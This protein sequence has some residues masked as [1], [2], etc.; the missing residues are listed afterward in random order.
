MLTHQRLVNIGCALPLLIAMGCAQKAPSTSQPPKL[1][2]TQQGIAQKV[3]NTIDTKVNPC[4]DFYQYA[5]GGWFKQTKLPGDQARWVRSFNVIAAQNDQ[6]LLDILKKKPASL[7]NEDAKVYAH[8]DGCMDEKRIETRGIEPLKPWLKKIEDI[9][10]LNGIFPVLAHMHN[11]R[12]GGLFYMSIG[13]DA[14]APTQYAARFGQSGLGLMYNRKG[15]LDK[16]FE[17]LRVAYV[18]YLESVFARLGMSA[19]DAKKGAADVMAFETELAKLSRERAALRNPDKTYNKIDIKALETS[20]KLPLSSYLGSRNLKKVPYAIVQVPEFFDGLH[21]LLSKTD[22]ATIKL[23]LKWH[24]VRATASLLSKQWDQ[25][26]FNF[27]GKTL[28]GQKE[29][30]ARWKRCVS[31]TNRAIGFQLGKLYVERSFAGQSKTIANE[32]VQTI[33]G[34]FDDHLN[35]VSW[36]DDT[37]RKRAR[38]KLHT[39]ANKIGYPDQWRDYTA[40]SVNPKSHF[41]NVL[42]ARAFENNRRMAK[43]GQPV[44]H[45]DWYM[46]PPTVNAY[47]TPFGNQIVFPAGILQAPFFDKSFP[48]AMNFGGI[49]MVI[50]HEITHGFDDGGRKFDAKGQLRMWWEPEAIKKFEARAQCVEKQYSSIEVQKGHNINGKLTL[51]ENIADWGGLKLAYLGYQRW[52]K[53]HP[54]RSIVSGLSNEQ[55]FFV[56]FAQTWCSMGTPENERQRLANDSHSPPKYRVNTTLS[57]TPAFHKAFAC[58]QGTPMNPKNQ[59]EVW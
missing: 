18:A 24:L 8:F 41:E 34:A 36:M 27:F 28:N 4:D 25:A 10:D 32:M 59:C 46:T 53:D 51:G 40:L 39:I 17:K 29:Q 48:M 6:L 20:S 54:E 37:T 23:Y 26:H 30:R 13:P 55:L 47:Y 11:H 21:P 12:I 1:N 38:G 58:G 9:T 52:L 16:R 19:E 22:M 14:K 33:E 7:S 45:K 44:D 43:Y 5:C 2:A 49:G 31:S 42:N 50:G 56:N 57:N 3:K 15:Y 35:K